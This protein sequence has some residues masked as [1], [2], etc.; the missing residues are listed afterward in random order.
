VRPAVQ[1]CIL[2]SVEQAKGVISVRLRDVRLLPAGRQAI[3]RLRSDI[4]IESERIIERGI[5]EGL[6][7]KMDPRVAAA[8]LLTSVLRVCEPDFSTHS[9]SSTATAVRQVYEIFRTGLF[10]GQPRW[11]GEETDLA[12]DW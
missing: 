8:A 3:D 6:F 7:R 10:S 12:I 9:R 4:A 1:G 2:A 11:I 5:N